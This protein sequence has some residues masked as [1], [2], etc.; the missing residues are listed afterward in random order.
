MAVGERDLMGGFAKGLKVLEAFGP[1]RQRLS[2][3]DASDIAGWT[4]DCPALP[5][6]ALRARLCRLRREVLLA[7]AED[8]ADRPCLA[9]GHATAGPAAAASRSTVRACGAQ[10][11]GVDP[12]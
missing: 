9:V 1:E 7:N 8:P 2:I 12:R 10:R 5:A 11:L 6:D 3:T 4:G